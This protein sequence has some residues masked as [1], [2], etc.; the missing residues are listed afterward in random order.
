MSLTNEIAAACTPPPRQSDRGGWD[1]ELPMAELPRPLDWRAIFGRDARTEIE[2]GAGSGLFLSTEA[3]RRPD[4]NFFAIEQDAGQVRRAADKWRRRKL[5]NTRIVRCDAL[6]FLEEF[7]A[8][9][10][11]DAYIILY[12]DPWP[13]KKHHKRRLFQP[14]LLP[15]LER[16]LKAGGLLT[17]KTD[18]TEYYDVIRPLLDSAPFLKLEWY[19]RLDLE[20][21]EDDVETNF[22]SK[23][24]E[25]GHPLHYLRYVKIP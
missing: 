5:L 20:P 18:V 12:S 13:K 8:A 11:I 19:K 4:V 25:K 23:A 15:I 16:T 24:K 9:E 22:Q 1:L 10:S 21:E 2:I 3:A 17:V 7:P 14:R 6:Y